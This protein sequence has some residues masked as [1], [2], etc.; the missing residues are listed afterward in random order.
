MQS[1]RGLL[2]VDAE[3]KEE[4]SVKEIIEWHP[5][6][7]PPDNDRSVLAKTNRHGPACIAVFSHD[8]WSI[9]ARSQ[10]TVYD[11]THWAEVPRG[12]KP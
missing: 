10:V 1:L 2:D 7:E 11:V 4:E 12:P 3:G 6:S 5:A 8:T 9:H